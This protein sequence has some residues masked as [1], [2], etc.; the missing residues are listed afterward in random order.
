MAETIVG[1][2]LQSETIAMQPSSTLLQP[3]KEVIFR[4]PVILGST[5]LQSSY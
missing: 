5:N 2:T 3:F 4:T 1:E